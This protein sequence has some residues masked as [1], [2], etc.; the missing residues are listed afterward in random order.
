M[1]HRSVLLRRVV[2]AVLALSALPALGQQE[3]RE[4]SEDADGAERASVIAEETMRDVRR[5]VGF[6]R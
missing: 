3:Q 5:I 6:L 2:C 1:D 4:Q